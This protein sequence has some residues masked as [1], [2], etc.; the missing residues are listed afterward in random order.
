M[1]LPV[2]PERGRRRN[3]QDQRLGNL[4]HS[5]TGSEAPRSRERSQS[6]LYPIGLP[7]NPVSGG[8]EESGSAGGLRDIGLWRNTSAGSQ[9]PAATVWLRSIVPTR[10]Q[11]RSRS[12]HGSSLR[13]HS[14]AAQD[15][16]LRW[17]SARSSGSAPAAAFRADRFVRLMA[18]AGSPVIPAQE[19]ADPVA[20]LFEPVGL[21]TFRA[22]YQ[23]RRP[24][25]IKRNAPGYYNDLITI[26]DVSRYLGDTRLTVPGVHLAMTSRD[27]AS[28]TPRTACWTT[29]ACRRSTRRAACAGSRPSSA[30][31]PSRT[32]KRS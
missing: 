6:P 27:P 20:R 8:P 12:S 16:A 24:L 13:P 21:E 11:Q 29:S 4:L 30:R 7:R 32:K 28:P 15:A 1:R 25:L 5:P 14:E 31:W 10:S 18:G 17:P 23:E 22:S 3:A 2:T 9:E 26:E 19:S